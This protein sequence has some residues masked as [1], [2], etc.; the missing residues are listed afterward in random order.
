MYHL[1]DST[2]GSMIV[3]STNKRACVNLSRCKAYGANQE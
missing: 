3:E 2:D 1:N